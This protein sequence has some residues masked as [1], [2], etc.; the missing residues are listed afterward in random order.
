[1]DQLVAVMITRQQKWDEGV[2]GAS[3]SVMKLVLVVGS[4]K[5]QAVCGTGQKEA[6]FFSISS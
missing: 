3:S 5:E 4:Q 2:C 1:M 6:F